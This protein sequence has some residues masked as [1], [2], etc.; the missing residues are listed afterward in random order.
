MDTTSQLFHT[1]SC[2]LLWTRCLLLRSLR[3][4]QMRI[5]HK[6]GTVHFGKLQLESDRLKDNIAVLARRLAKAITIIDAVPSAENEEAK[7]KVCFASQHAC[8]CCPILTH[9]TDPLQKTVRKLCASWPRWEDCMLAVLRLT[10][11]TGPLCSIC[12]AIRPLH[13]AVDE[14][15][16]SHHQ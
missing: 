10:V 11:I 7:K 9:V 1:P 2:H 16:L 6:N 3:R 4:L 12:D 13:L 15:E 5:D 8:R 14:P